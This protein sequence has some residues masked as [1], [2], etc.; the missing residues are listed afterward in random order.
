[1]DQRMTNEMHR[2][3]VM[4]A[5]EIVAEF[6]LEK[7]AHPPS[8]LPND[9]LENLAR[10]LQSKGKRVFFLLFLLVVFEVVSG[11]LGIFFKSDLLVTI[12]KGF[13]AASLLLWGAY[14]LA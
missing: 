1:M 2:A 8:D 9:R 10:A 4:A 3:D 13:V 5:F 14:M 12:S 6:T 7:R 11:V